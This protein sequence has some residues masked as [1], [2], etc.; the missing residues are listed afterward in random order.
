VPASAGQSG[1]VLRPTE[2]K[3]K[4]YLDADAVLALPEKTPVEV[5]RQQGPWYFAR[6]KNKE[7]FVRLLQVRLDPTDAAKAEAAAQSTVVTVARGISGGP[8]VTSGI[9][10]FSEEELRKAQPN[11]AELQRMLG[12]TASADTAAAFAQRGQLTARKLA[13]NSE[14]G[15]PLKEKK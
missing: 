7:G 13:Y 11:P 9:R 4:P 14:N 12:Y 5:L 10:G 8:I 2:L 6:A 3:I 1:T 15:K